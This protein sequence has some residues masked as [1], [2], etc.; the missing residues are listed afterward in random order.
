VVGGGVAE[1]EGE[2]LEGVD[3]GAVRR[4]YIGLLAV[5]QLRRLNVIARSVRVA[6]SQP[7]RTTTPKCTVTS[8]HHQH[9]LV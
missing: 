9:I 1:V 3:E 6:T 8:Y 5:K 4:H 2:L 7:H